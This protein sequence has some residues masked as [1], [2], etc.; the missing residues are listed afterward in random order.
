M[1]STVTVS[2]GASPAGMT[3]AMAPRRWPPGCVCR[4]DAAP[5]GEVPRGGHPGFL[6][7]NN[8]V[9]LLS[10]DH[11]ERSPST[12]RCGPIRVAPF[13]LRLC[14]AARFLYDLPRP[15]GAVGLEH[16]RTRARGRTH[17]HTHVKA[18]CPRAPSGRA[19]VPPRPRGARPSPGTSLGLRSTFFFSPPG[20]PVGT[21]SV[22]TRPPGVCD[23]YINMFITSEL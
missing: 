6:S 20:W 13:F 9:G 3:D 8:S 2:A 5:T 21:L 10:S 17:K 11:I 14:D 15:R 18:E 4:T 12:L 22:K 7:S 23:C 1:L 16:L 19:V